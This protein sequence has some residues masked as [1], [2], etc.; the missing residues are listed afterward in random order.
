MDQEPLGQQEQAHDGQAEVV[1]DLVA[2]HLV[3]EEGVVVSVDALEVAGD[4]AGRVD[5][6]LIHDLT[7][8]NGSHGQEVEHQ[9]GCGVSQQS[10]DDGSQAGA[11]DGGDEGVDAEGVCQDGR[12]VAANSV[13]GCVAHGDLAAVA[14]A[15]VQAGDRD[16][17]DLDQA[18]QHQGVGLKAQDY[19]QQQ[20]EERGGDQGSA[21]LVCA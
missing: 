2:L 13:E 6:E 5:Q 17:V 8:G 12:G 10:A 20:A 19:G 14:E 21:V 3:A 1:P 18:A 4:L 9:L 11:D 16:H 15:E 7:E